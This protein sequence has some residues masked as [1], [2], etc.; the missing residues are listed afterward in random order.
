MGIELLT[1]NIKRGSQVDQGVVVCRDCRTTRRETSSS[2]ICINRLDPFVVAG[3][4]FKIVYDIQE[5][6]VKC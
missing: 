1:W 6:E 2:A 3:A 5:L 4:W